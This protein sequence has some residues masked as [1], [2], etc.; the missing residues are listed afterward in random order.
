MIQF[1]FMLTRDDVTIDDARDVLAGLR[2][3]GLRYVGFKDVG[4]PPAVLRHVT[5][6]PTR[7]AWR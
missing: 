1:I 6:A 5:A 7:P 2:D 3:S 4:P